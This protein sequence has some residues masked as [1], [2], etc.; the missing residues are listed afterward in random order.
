M[1][2]FFAVLLVAVVLAAFVPAAHAEGS[3]RFYVE[4]PASASVGDTVSVVVSR[5]GQEI[6]IKTVLEESTATE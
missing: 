3:V 6:E 2:K 4:A 5:S 1:R